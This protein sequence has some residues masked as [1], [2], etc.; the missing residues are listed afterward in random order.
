MSSPSLRSSNELVELSQLMRLRTYRNIV[1]VAASAVVLQFLLMLR[2]H[3]IYLCTEKTGEVVAETRWK[4]EDFYHRRLLWPV[5]HSPLWWS[6]RTSDN[7]PFDAFDTVASLTVATQMTENLVAFSAL[8]LLVGHQEEH[9]A[10]KKWWAV[11]V[12]ICLKWSADCLHMVQLMPLP[13]QNPIISCIIYIQTGFTFLVL[14][15]PGYPG[16]EAVNTHTH[17][18]NGHLSGTTQAGR[19]QKAKPIW[20]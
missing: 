9:P 10:S 14:A 3:C 13:S 17:L 6:H 5:H 16:K 12:V 7:F 15:Y 1:V 11:G 20:I 19:Y 18:F 2:P 8:T 4:R